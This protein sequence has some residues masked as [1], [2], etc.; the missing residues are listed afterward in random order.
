MYCKCG[1]NK[2]MKHN[3]HEVLTIEKATEYYQDVFIGDMPLTIEKWTCYCGRVA[4]KVKDSNDE[5]LTTF[6]Q[7]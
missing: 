6:G 5:I 3:K 1:S 2:E 4:G 7:I